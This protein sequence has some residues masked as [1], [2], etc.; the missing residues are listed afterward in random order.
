MVECVVGAVDWD[1]LLASRLLLE[2]VGFL[3]AFVFTTLAP[4]SSNVFT[5]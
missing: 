1:L 4:L 2:V 3:P 5:L